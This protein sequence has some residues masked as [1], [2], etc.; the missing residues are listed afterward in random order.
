MIL[1]T[2]SLLLLKARVH[3]ITGFFCLDCVLED[4]NKN[5]KTCKLICD[6]DPWNPEIQDSLHK[7]LNHTRLLKKFIRDGIVFEL[8]GISYVSRRLSPPGTNYTTCSGTR[9]IE[10]DLD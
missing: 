8:D 5:G 9:K 2:F 6:N 1:K 4:P 3:I 7:L 10:D